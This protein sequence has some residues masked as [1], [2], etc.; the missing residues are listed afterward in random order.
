VNNLDE[1][2][3]PATQI[4][5]NVTIS[6]PRQHHTATL[7]NSG[8][9]FF[10]GGN[11]DVGNTLSSTLI[12]DPVT[13]TTIAGPPL[14]TPRE[15]HTATLL[16]DGTVLIAGGRQ[17]VIPPPPN[18]NVWATAEIY[19]PVAGT[20][21]T[22]VTGSGPRFAQSD[23][24][25]DDGRSLI[26]GGSSDQNNVTSLATADFFGAGA[27]TPL[28]AAP[29]GALNQVRREF[30]MTKLTDSWVLAVGGIDSSGSRLSSGELFEPGAGFDR[31]LMGPAVSLANARSGHTATRLQDGR[32]LVLGGTGSGNTA[33]NS[34]EFYNGPF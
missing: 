1:I 28:P 34:A 29:N 30:S 12:Y 15:R 25:L 9:V 14:Q 10:A 19:D 31:F 21:T 2:W 11:D 24:L 6:S 8:K 16:P 32:V 3:D 5:T 23:V 18:F 17:A 33:I 4:W 13:A 27:F 22:L 7:L 26:A 20:T